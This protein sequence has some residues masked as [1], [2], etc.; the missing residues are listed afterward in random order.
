[1]A[2]KS[3]VGKDYGEE[4]ITMKNHSKPMGLGSKFVGANLSTS[5][6]VEKEYG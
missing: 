2:W 5:K 4:E 3:V 6:G 1:M